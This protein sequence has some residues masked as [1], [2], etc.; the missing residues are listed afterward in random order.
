MA[1][2][3]HGTEGAIHWDFERMNEL[4][5]FTTDG[6]HDGYTTIQ[7]SPAH[8]GHIHFNP[9]PAVGL[10]YDDLKVIEVYHFL[11]SIANGKQGKPGF[12]EALAVGNVLAAIVRSWASERWKKIID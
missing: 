4:Q 3:I 6:T 7:S 5:V 9:G 2:E 12:A 10:G 11:Q 1:F 8:P